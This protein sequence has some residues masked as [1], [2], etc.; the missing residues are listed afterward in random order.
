MAEP[1]TEANQPAVTADL[2]AAI[3]RLE[4]R[5]ET[6][7]RRITIRFCIMLVVWVAALV[8]ILKHR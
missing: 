3:E 5:I 7:V 2:H 4:T 1:V 6:E 8:A